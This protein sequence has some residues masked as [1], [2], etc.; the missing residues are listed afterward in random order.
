MAR[1]NNIIGDIAG[2]GR[3]EPARCTRADHRSS[4]RREFQTRHLASE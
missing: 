4:A 3:T 1:G 2:L